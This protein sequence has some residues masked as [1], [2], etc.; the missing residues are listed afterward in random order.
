MSSEKRYL[1]SFGV[2]VAFRAY[3]TAENP[4]EAE[5]KL[6]DV[7][8]DALESV[9]IEDNVAIC[10]AVA[11]DKDRYFEVI[12]PKEGCVFNHDHEVGPEDCQSHN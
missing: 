11:L 4:E 12:K 8:E 3:V 5:E 2:N 7:F 9:Y 1:V 10:D 6:K